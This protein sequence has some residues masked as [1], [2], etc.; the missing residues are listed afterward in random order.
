MNLV[1][2]HVDLEATTRHVSLT[3]AAIDT[4]GEQPFVFDALT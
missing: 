1:F 3:Y 2:I 4:F